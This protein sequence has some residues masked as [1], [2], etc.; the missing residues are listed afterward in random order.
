MF[1]LNGTTY[2]VTDGTTTGVGTA[3]GIN[4]GTMWARTSISN[5]ETQFGLVYGFAAQ[6]TN[7][8]QSGTGV[9]QFQVTSSSGTNTLYDIVY[10]AGSNAN[11]V[12]VDVPSALPTFVQSW[13]FNFVT[14]YP[15]TFETG[16]Y[17]AFTTFVSETSTPSESFAG[18]Y[19]TPVT[20]TDSQID[21]LL[22]TQGDFSLEFWH[23][24]SLTPV[25]AYHPFTYLASTSKPLVYDVD[26][27]FEDGS[28]IYVRINNS[29]MQATTTPPVFS[30]RWRHFALTYSQPYVILVRGRRVRSEAGDEL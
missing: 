8:S 7:V 22:G 24:L 19:R 6:P 26:V 9:F 18:A 10:T 1:N 17:N 5:V 2:L 4:P 27:D 13:P 25:S 3:A 28:D 12:K 14:S 30:S 11:L 21:T 20:S 16:G 15:L 29:V 23:S